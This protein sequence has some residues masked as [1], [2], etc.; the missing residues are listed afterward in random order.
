MGLNISSYILV[1][2][3]FCVLCSNSTYPSSLVTQ[4][5]CLRWRRTLFTR[6][7]PLPPCLFSDFLVQISAK[8]I[9]KTKFA[10]PSLIIFPA[11]TNHVLPT[12]LKSLQQMLVA[13]TVTTVLMLPSNII[14]GQQ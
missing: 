7:I 13:T 11:S 8:K 12:S 5:G 10:T 14:G 6:C 4:L 1:N 9:W 2:S 3:V